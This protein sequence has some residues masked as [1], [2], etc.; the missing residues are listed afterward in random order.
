M[1]FCRFVPSLLDESFGL[2]ITFHSSGSLRVLIFLIPS[3][4]TAGLI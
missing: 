4:I 2:S 1:H 3:Q